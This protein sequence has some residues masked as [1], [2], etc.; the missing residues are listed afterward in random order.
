M[1]P[2][3]EP[4]RSGTGSRTPLHEASNRLGETPAPQAAAS[5]TPSDVDEDRA[6]I[7]YLPV[8]SST[9]EPASGGGATVI[10]IWG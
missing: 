1:R 5:G 6:R 2:A 9:S 3:L 7:Y 4:A 8:R 10:R